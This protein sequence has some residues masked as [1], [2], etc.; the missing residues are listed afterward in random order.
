MKPVFEA[1]LNL[2]LANFKWSERRF[3]LPLEKLSALWLRLQQNMQTY[4]M[5][6]DDVNYS[7]H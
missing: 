6:T 5:H 7:K 4:T 3:R 1:Q 2:K